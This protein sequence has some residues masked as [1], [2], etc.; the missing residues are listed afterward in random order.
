MNKLKLYLTGFDFLK[1][2][3]LIFLGMII[4]NLCTLVNRKLKKVKYNKELK[5][6]SNSYDKN[7]IMSLD[8]GSPY[9]EPQNIT[10]NKN[11]DEFYLSIP[12]EKLDSILKLDKNFISRD[13]KYFDKINI[14]ELG[15]EMKISNFSEVVEKHRNIIADEF[16][17]SANRREIIFNGKKFGIKSISMNRVTEEENSYLNIDFYTTDYFTHKVMKSVYKEIK[18][19]Y[20]KFDE[21]LKEKLNDYYPFMTSLGI[22]TLVILDKYSYDKQIVFCRRSKRVSNMNGESKWHV[23]M[24]G[25][26]SVTDLDGYS[27]NLNKA[28][29]RGMYEELGIKEND[30]KKSAFGDLF[31]VTDNF[32]IGLTN[33]VILNRNF[34]ELKKCYNTAQDGEFETDDI[35]SIGFSKQELSDFLSKNSTDMTLACKY[36]IDMIIGRGMNME[37][38]H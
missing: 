6:T 32:E 34:E 18:E 21:N 16:L 33:I 13:D 19:Q 12:E 37:L 27:I 31:L 15:N 17:E 3:F 23:S 10:S 4:P 2:I 1:D 26:V 36:S 7:G 14:E 5:N 25:G 11:K 24:N 22:N 38:S 20:I 9:Y 29:K 28:V 35:K 30:I 8:H